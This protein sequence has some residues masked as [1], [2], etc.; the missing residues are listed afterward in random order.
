ML[1]N[2]PDDFRRDD[3]EVLNEFRQKQVNF[4][5][6]ERRNEID[7]S[8][9][10][11]IGALAGLS[12][13]AVVGWFVLAPRYQNDNPED[14]PVITRPQGIVKMQPSEPGDVELASQERTV[15]DIIE[16]K[17]ATEEQARIVASVEQ[18]DA[19][20]IERLVDETVLTV[21]EET[22]STAVAESLAK[23]ASA[24]VVVDTVK[25]EADVA[26]KAEPVV[27]A[28]VAKTADV[29]EL[30]AVKNEPAKIKVADKPAVIQSGSWQV[31]LMSS[32]NKAAVEKSW[33]MMSKKYSVLKD[34]P[35]EIESADLGAKGTFYRLKAG[36][37]ATKNDATALCNAIKTAGGSCFTAKK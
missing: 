29:K 1:S 22:A 27:A 18:P 9:S 10:L 3:E 11:F 5:L 32:P 33:Q 35:H 13:A 4:D 16:K 26:Q 15:Y 24:A 34:L 30:P 17:P 20:A 19:E 14:V 21:T 28:A 2:F 8:R 37:F 36:A 6:E 31:Q 7:N 12:M 23:P 25:K